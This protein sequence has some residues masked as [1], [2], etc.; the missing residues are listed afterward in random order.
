MDNGNESAAAQ[1]GQDRRAAL[2][3]WREVMGRSLAVLGVMSAGC[4]L[5]WCMVQVIQ[6]LLRAELL[7]LRGALQ[8]HP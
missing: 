7:V 4:P 2:K 1:T 3:A 6:S 5:V 8:F